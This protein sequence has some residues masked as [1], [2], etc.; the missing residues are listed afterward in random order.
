[1]LRAHAFTALGRSAVPGWGAKILQASKQIKNTNLLDT[2][3][4]WYEL[5][6]LII[7]EHSYP[8]TVFIPKH[9]NKYF[10]AGAR[11]G[12]LGPRPRIRLKLPALKEQSLNHRGNPLSSV[13]VFFFFKIIKLWKITTRLKHSAIVVFCF[14]AL[15]EE[16]DRVPG[17]L[18]GSI[19]ILLP[20]PTQL[21]FLTSSSAMLSR[22]GSTALR[23]L[24]CSC[25]SPVCMS[26][27]VP[28][29]RCLLLPWMFSIICAHT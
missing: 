10:F 9:E 19:C 22:L 24:L 29:T 1:M 28:N 20:F 11:G 5:V 3:W 23:S 26:Y 27:V 14:L 25:L 13:L 12:V 17:E 8:P 16:K 21:P 4:I 6:F 18:T 7:W 15:N 2:K